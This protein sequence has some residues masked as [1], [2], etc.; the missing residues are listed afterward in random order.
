MRLM[1]SICFA[2][3]I[4]PIGM[5]YSSDIFSLSTLTE[6]LKKVTKVANELGCN[7]VVNTLCDIKPE[8]LDQNSNT[9]AK[10]VRML[11]T[12]DKLYWDGKELDFTQ[13]F[14]EWAKVLGD[15]Y[16]SG[17]IVGRGDGKMW[18]KSRFIYMDY[19]IDVEVQRPHNKGPYVA[20]EV[21]PVK[22][23][24][25]YLSANNGASPTG[26]NIPY[27]NMSYPYAVDFGGAIVDGNT[28]KENVLKYSEIHMHHRQAN[29]VIMIDFKAPVRS[30]LSY[31]DSFGSMPNIARVLGVFPGRKVEKENFK[32]FYSDDNP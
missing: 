24:R 3:I 32:R 12:K 4:W 1:V 28:S 26:R 27:D 8:T 6:S 5:V 10:K 17:E 16:I 20:Y 30:S 14:K 18:G 21:R 31:Y 29:G 25:L 22:I 13:P 19:G 23:I 11:V 2:L 9:S 15:N 7:N